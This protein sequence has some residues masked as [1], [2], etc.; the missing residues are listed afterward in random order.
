[1]LSRNRMRLLGLLVAAMLGLVL[2]APTQATEYTW[3]PTA[4]GT[5]NWDDAL[6]NWGGGFPNAVDDTATLA[7]GLA[8]AQTIDLNQ[9]ITIGT[10]NIGDTGGA[11]ATLLESG[12]A[13]SLIFG[14][15]SGAAAINKA[16]AGSTVTDEISAGIMLNSNLSITNAAAAGDLTISGNID[17]SGGAKTLTKL[18]AGTL[19]LSGTNSYTGLTTVSAGTLKVGNAR[20]LGSTVAATTVSAGATLDLNGVILEAE[21]ITINGTG[22]GAAGALVNNSATAASMAGIL[23]LGSAATIGGTGNITIAQPLFGTTALTKVGG[24]TLILSATSVR[25]GAVTINGGAIRMDASDALGLVTINVNSGGSLLINHTIPLANA[26]NRFIKINDGG[27][28]QAMQ[29]VG[30]LTKITVGSTPDTSVTFKAD[31]GATLTLTQG[32]GGSRLTGGVA[33]AKL[34]I[35]GPGIVDI[36][37]GANTRA[38]D[39]IGDWILKSGEFRIRDDTELGN[40]ANDVYFQGG[41]LRIGAA[42][43]PLGASRVLDFTHASGGAID[44]TGG[45]LTLSTP[46]QLVGSNV[47][48]KIGTNS[49]TV[50]AANTGF[51]G[52]ATISGG[53]VLEI[54]DP[55]AL[56]TSKITAATGGRFNIRYNLDGALPPLTSAMQIDVTGG[57]IRGLV[58]EVGALPIAVNPI[59]AA[60]NV[61]ST[62]ILNSARPTDN[63]YDGIAYF[64]NV[65]LAEGASLRMD[66]VD[67]ATAA[68]L[69]LP[70]NASVQNISDTSKVFVTDVTG[71]G[72]T[73]SMLTLSGTK[74]LTFAGTLTNVDLDVTNTATTAL[75]NMTN[76]GL[77]SKFNLN[78][79]SINLHAGTLRVGGPSLFTSGLPLPQ[80][81]D[82]Y[83]D[84]GP[85]TFNVSGGAMHVYLGADG[86]PATS[87]TAAHTINMT[88]GEIRGL[89]NEVDA[90]PLTINTIGAAINVLGNGT[91]TMAR[92]SN[93]TYDGFVYYPNVTVADGVY[94]NLDHNDSALATNLS[95]AGN[96]SIAALTSNKVFVKDVTGTGGSPSVLTV[97]GAQTVNL[98]GTLTNVD[99]SV[100]N[101]GTTALQNMTN[102]GLG[103]K[104]NLNG[105][106]I[107]I[108]AG[109]TVQA[110]G[111]CL[112]TGG[113]PSTTKADYYFD[114]GPGTFNVYGGA[115]NV[116]L[117]A[118]GNTAT[119]LTTAHTVNLYDGGTIRAFINDAT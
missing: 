31:A 30:I 49:L 5:Y 107:N 62:G 73:P 109:S 26:G 81:A 7:I 6:S 41:T 54:Q 38:T 46:G 67:P 119:G 19:I 111:P 90:L 14:V 83:F 112:Y 64:T 20:A 27:T 88:G 115:L 78:G 86:N 36:G 55:A 33:G 106:S 66:Q 11:Y 113:L 13:G 92:N 74:N 117:G 96:A 99:L 116:Y 60:I 10:L 68:K 61:L 105:R 53:G 43:N 110:G 79:R 45:T 87:L 57:E 21:S 39:I 75:G 97:T 70:G 22:V 84:I 95:L 32:A 98:V 59:G 100:T 108:Q 48:N 44:T 35:E 77:G 40:V 17:E 85:G 71:T 24:N 37:D 16:A 76:V 91:L 82:Y 12:T 63:A 3:T 94:L 18:G 29:T 8:G 25:T 28:L 89:V 2:V 65:T 103:S 47:L 34:N 9:A 72:G 101:T 23:T 104:F 58:N 42:I 80:V 15:T 50:T 56:G 69:F 102:V 1:M 118:D 114:I 4:G 51:S 52:P 93:L